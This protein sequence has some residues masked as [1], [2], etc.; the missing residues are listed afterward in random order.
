MHGQEQGQGPKQEQ[1][2]E[3]EP[4]VLQVLRGPLRSFHY[5]PLPER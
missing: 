5:V 4:Q 2:P 3:P 1:E